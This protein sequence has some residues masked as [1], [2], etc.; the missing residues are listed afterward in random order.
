MILIGSCASLRYVIYMYCLHMCVY[1]CMYVCV[2]I[3]IC[4]CMHIYKRC[5]NVQERQRVAEEKKK[6]DEVAAKAV[7]PRS[8]APAT[9]CVYS[10]AHT[11]HSL[12]HSLLCTTH[13]HSRMLNSLRLITPH[14]QLP[15]NHIENAD[16]LQGIIPFL[17]RHLIRH[18]KGMYGIHIILS[19]CY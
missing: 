10:Y 7:R 6:I 3:C 19:L 15:R 4:V 1:V 9:V 5:M 16:R 12:A 14:N 13:T 18:I 8:T 11:D 2:C 17:H